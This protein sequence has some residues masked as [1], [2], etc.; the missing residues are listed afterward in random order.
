MTP[1][2]ALRSF[3]TPKTDKR[4]IDSWSKRLVVTYLSAEGV[5]LSSLDVY[6]VSDENEIKKCPRIIHMHGLLR[7]SFFIL[8]GLSRKST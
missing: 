4:L 7:A 5:S 2:T 3:G 8:V 1:T 6:L